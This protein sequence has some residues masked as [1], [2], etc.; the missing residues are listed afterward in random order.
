MKYNFLFFLLWSILCS[1]SKKDQQPADQSSMTGIWKTQTVMDYTYDKIAT[2]KKVDTLIHLEDSNKYFAEYKAGGQFNSFT[3]K[4]ASRMNNVSGTYVYNTTTK[5]LTM[6][7]P[8]NGIK[9]GTYFNERI[10][11][12]SHVTN[13]DNS[14]KLTFIN[15]NHIQLS[16]YYY[17]YNSYPLYY[18]GPLQVEVDS[19]VRITILSKQ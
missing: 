2:L 5:A 18:N 14:S 8:A 3:L 6:T 12:G 16:F 17:Q 4:N 1:C 10:E 13:D 9:P 11:T 19:V 7:Y 15:N